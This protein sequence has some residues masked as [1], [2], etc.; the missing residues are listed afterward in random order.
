[1]N[2][3]RIYSG[4][5]AWV[6]GIIAALLFIVFAGSYLFD[7]Q[8]RLY[9]ERNINR[10]LKGYTVTLEGAHFQPLDIGLTLKGVTIAQDANPRPPVAFFPVFKASLNWLPLM[11]GRVVGELHLESPRLHID[12]TQLLHEA[13]REF[14]VK[15]GGWQQAFEAIYPL[16]INRLTISDG[17]ITY[18]D[19]DPKRPLHI[20]K[21]G[22]TSS[23]IRNIDSPDKTYP[24]PFHLEGIIFDKGS[25]TIDGAAD[26]LDKPFLGIRAS[27]RL[28]GAPLDGFKPVL[29]RGNL[30]LTGGVIDSAGELEYSAKVKNARVTELAIKGV[31]LDYV[32]SPATA[33]AEEARVEKVREVAKKAAA[34]PGL[35]MRVDRLHISNS[36]F[37]YVN[38]AASTPYRAFFTEFNLTMTNLSNRF[39]RGAA[40]ARMT[41]MFMGNGPTTATASFRPETKGPDFDLN[42]AVRDTRLDS[43]NNLVRAYSNLDLSGGKFAMD[44]DV[45]IKDGRIN[46]YIEPFFKDM[47]VS[48]RRNES[49]KKLSHTLYVTFVKVV[50]KVFK[51][52]ERNTVATRATISGTVQDPKVSTTQIIG[53]L[54]KNAFFH[55]ILP[56]IEKE[57]SSAQTGKKPRH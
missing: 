20:S 53:N 30:K 31:R 42:V 13:A 25:L 10:E 38:E 47:V 43:M 55:A 44:L 1:M 34:E 46:G 3:R 40:D 32:H 19:T 28:G 16:K 23:N 17:D 12:M 15:K 52:R 50:A 5:L 56:G 22:V 37:G 4:R 21:L 9:M 54:I 33:K 49:E 45:H 14:P 24:S 36:E 11:R 57:V 6:S 48:D 41:G 18:I 29:A 26:F 7:S 35:V 51:D 8:L 27:Y 2:R 39:S